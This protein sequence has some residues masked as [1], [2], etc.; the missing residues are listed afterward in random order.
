MRGMWRGMIVGITIFSAVITPSTN[1]FTFF[2]MAIPIWLLYGVYILLRAS[3][4]RRKRSGTHKDADLHDDEASYLGASGSR[5]P[6]ATRSKKPRP[7]PAL[8]TT[9]PAGTTAAGTTA[10]DAN[11]N[12]DKCAYVGQNDILPGLHTPGASANLKGDRGAL[13]PVQSLWSNNA[14][15]GAGYCAGA[16]NDLPL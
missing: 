2:A 14:A 11:E 13:F 8:K 12:G 10:F 4:D 3:L 6:S 15:S 16:G 9:S 7:T 1:T 5:S